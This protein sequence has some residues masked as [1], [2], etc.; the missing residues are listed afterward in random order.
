MVVQ[1]RPRR[2]SHPPERRPHGARSDACRPR[3]PHPCGPDHRRSASV[4]SGRSAL[5]VSGSIL[6]L[7]PIKIGIGCERSVDPAKFGQKFGQKFDKLPGLGRSA[8]EVLGVKVKQLR[9]SPI[10]RFFWGASNR[11]RRN[12]AVYKMGEDPDM[13]LRELNDWIGVLRGIDPEEYKSSGLTSLPIFSKS[14]IEVL[15]VNI[16]SSEQSV[17]LFSWNSA[18]SR[19]PRKFAVY[20]IGC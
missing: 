17:V 10:T 4:N 11:S 14:I 5:T 13:M 15:K 7:K 2:P 19:F 3:A 18:G 1:R 12:F 16:R 20:L 6:M 9:R 8:L